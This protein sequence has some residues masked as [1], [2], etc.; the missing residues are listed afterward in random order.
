MRP[1]DG[2]ILPNFCMQALQSQALS[3]Y[4]DGSQTRSFCY[5]GDL[6]RGLIALMRSEESRPTN[7]G[8]PIELTVSQVAEA[9]IQLTG[10]TAGLRRLPLPQ[11]DPKQRR[12][13]ISRAVAL[14]WKPE[15]NFDSGLKLTL[16][17]FREELRAAGG[18][19]QTPV[20]E[21]T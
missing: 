4:G 1:D 17:S 20:L 2:R 3:V 16:E 5:V 13:D 21:K 14:G 18:K 15:I 8:N 7:V 6:V 10:S 19:V 12:P 11:N 9:V